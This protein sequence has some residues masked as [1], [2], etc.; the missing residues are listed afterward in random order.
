MRQAI[1]V[2]LLAAALL[3]VS[4]G[5]SKIAAPEHLGTW[6]GTNGGDIAAK[7]VVTGEAGNYAAEMTTVMEGLDPS[8]T[9]YSGG[10]ADESGHV[11]FKDGDHT[12]TLSPVEGGLMM[13]AYEH[14]EYGGESVDLDYRMARE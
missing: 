1:A 10:Q 5:G 9:S 11:T 4:C 7:I 12:L 8:T 3:L 6:V 2:L 14:N 13:T